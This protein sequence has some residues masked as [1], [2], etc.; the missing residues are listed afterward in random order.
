MASSERFIPG[1]VSVTF[2]ALKPEQI[3]ALAVQAQLR[4]IEWGGD[5]HVP[6]GDLRAAAAVQRSCANSGLRISAY[7]SY[8]RAG[9]R[10]S[11]NPSSQRV[12][13]TALALG[14][15]RIRVWAGN[16]GSATADDDTR[17][18][19]VNDLCGICAA[20]TK[21]AIS[22]G[23]EFHDRTVTDIPES[24]ASLCHQVGANNLRCNWQPR[25]GTSTSIGLADIAILQPHLGDVHVFHLGKD[26]SRL[27]LGAGIESWRQ[28]LAAIAHG[29]EI[30]RHASLEFVK[31]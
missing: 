4:S 14:T 12:L 27:P 10:G 2:R 24:A 1:L 17:Q 15:S 29:D 19:T 18:R 11:S 7:G 31:T 20:A 21:E 26:R 23:L 9:V 13:E 6:H 5:V 16:C 8:F 28:Y 3:M 22:I 25:V 30:P